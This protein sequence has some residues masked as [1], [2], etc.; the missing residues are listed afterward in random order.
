MDVKFTNARTAFHNAVF[1]RT[2][3]ELPAPLRLLSA[4]MPQST[5]PPSNHAIISLPSFITPVCAGLHNVGIDSAS[6]ISTSFDIFRCC[7]GLDKHPIDEN[8]F[9]FKL[10]SGADS[11]FNDGSAMLIRSKITDMM[12]ATFVT[13]DFPDVQSFIEHI[14]KHRSS[15]DA[16][17]QFEVYAHWPA[18]R[19]KNTLDAAAEML[20]VEE[21]MCASGRDRGGRYSIDG[22]LHFRGRDY[23]RDMD[24]NRV[25][26]SSVLLVRVDKPGGQDHNVT[27]LV[28]RYSDKKPVLEVELSGKTDVPGRK[29]SFDMSRPRDADAFGKLL[30]FDEY[31]RSDLEAARRR[32]GSTACANGMLMYYAAA[33]ISA[34]PPSL[35]EYGKRLLDPMPGDDAEQE[36][37]EEAFNHRAD[38]EVLASMAASIM[39][40]K[41]KA[42]YM[43]SAL[44]NTSKPTLQWF[45]W[46]PKDLW[47][48]TVEP[49][50]RKIAF[51]ALGDVGS[52]VEKKVSDSVSFSEMEYHFNSTLRRSIQPWKPNAFDASALGRREDV[53]RHVRKHSDNQMKR[54]QASRDPLS[55]EMMSSLSHICYELDFMSSIDAAG[56]DLFPFSNG[57]QR[58]S[59][60]FA[61][62]PATPSMRISSFDAKA[63]LEL[64]PA[65]SVSDAQFEAFLQW[66][67]D[68]FFGHREVTL[69]E[70]DK[71]A[72]AMT[73]TPGGCPEAGLNLWLGP[74]Y[75]GTALAASRC[76][77]GRWTA[78]N[79]AL[80][81]GKR[82]ATQLSQSLLEHGVCDGK[83][84]EEM[85]KVAPAHVAFFDEFNSNEKIGEAVKAKHA[86]IKPNF[87]KNLVPSST[88]RVHM[89]FHLKFGHIT[90]TSGNL[91][92]V[93]VLAN[94][95]PVTNVDDPSIL[96]RLEV[97]PFHH[98]G[99][100]KQEDLDKAV[101][102]GKVL[103]AHKDR[104]FV[105]HKSRILGDSKWYGVAARYLADR[106]ISTRGGN[107]E[108]QT[109]RPPDKD[110][111][112]WHPPSKYHDEHK[113]LY[114]DA[115]KKV[116]TPEIEYTD[117]HAFDAVKVAAD[118]RIEQCTGPRSK[119]CQLVGVN[120]KAKFDGFQTASKGK[121]NCFCGAKNTK[122]ACHFELKDF[123]LQL[124]VLAPRAW[125]YFA[126]K[127]GAVTALQRALGIEER[128][129]PQKKITGEG[130]KNNV[131]FG[132]RLRAETR[133]NVDGTAFGK[134]E[135]EDGSLG[136]L[137][138][139]RDA[140][141]A[142]PSV[143]EDEEE[144]Y[145]VEDE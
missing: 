71:V 1:N 74:F 9:W 60:P 114:L 13:S 101:M 87:I 34:N 6:P 126:K 33:L 78:F 26:L 118:L 86:Y 23:E 24:T 93:V 28:F 31:L 16:T 97:T 130:G 82:A 45:A 99:F 116:S 84:C 8:P 47:A 41:V 81:G 104:C 100:V 18:M 67:D 15:D 133:D 58:W 56:T 65:G 42:C 122:L 3:G 121:D 22:T 115:V 111:K 5:A 40:D 102:E 53:V 94:G 88:E 106:V 108:G 27:G 38:P 7:A 43:P 48:Q 20:E 140:S 123:M 132:F 17:L 37:M 138:S 110:C 62:G 21:A 89:P 44:T 139:E 11:E 96:N 137:D 85:T 98:Y 107:S 64:P 80:L 70:L 131:I 103:E 10:E 61:F 29:I 57:V 49:E 73:G 112:H 119:P 136:C 127:P 4:T 79:K 52:L 141:G 30:R 143:D 35:P 54:L 95:I 135:A 25:L 90:A 92:R 32:H 77:K 76:G 72:E 142:G 91:V 46:D 51:K 125:Q 59:P 2:A 39:G 14:D 144:P 109:A 117:A 63:T 124:N 36:S 50:V 134:I 68:E 69:R 83:P 75:V 113:K 55:K 105:V 12:K 66:V 19:L 128:V 129:I 145:K 120:F